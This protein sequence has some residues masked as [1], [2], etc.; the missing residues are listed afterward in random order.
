MKIQATIRT[1]KKLIQCILKLSAGGLVTDGV[2]LFWSADHLANVASAA[3][4]T[5][6]PRKEASSDWIWAAQNQESWRD[7]VM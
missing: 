7:Q 3:R 2:D 5:N 6:D 1:F 4:W